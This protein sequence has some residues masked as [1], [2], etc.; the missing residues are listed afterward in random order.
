MKEFTDFTLLI[1]DGS[2]VI[3]FNSIPTVDEFFD[4]INFYELGCNDGWS[5]N[6]ETDEDE[7]ESFF[8]ELTKTINEVNCN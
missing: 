3:T 8:E 5:F 2:Y 6:D 1:E 7:L 4:V